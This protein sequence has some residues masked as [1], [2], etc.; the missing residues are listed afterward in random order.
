MD[1]PG[2]A[3]KVAIVTGAAGAIGTA[4]TDV[5]AARGARVVAVDRDQNSLQAAFRTSTRSAVM[6]QVADVTREE[7]MEALVANVVSRLGSVDI[8]IANAGVEG[9]VQLISDYPLAEFR[10]VLEVNVVGVFLGLKYV[11]PA[12]HARGAG[13]VVNIASIAGLMGSTH[14]AA[15]T[16]SK[17]AVIGLTRSAALECSG[18]AVRVNAVCPGFIDSPMLDAIAKGRRVRDAKTID[19][20]VPLKRLGTV[21]EVASL[22][23]FVASDEASYVT[24]S[25][26]TVD[27]GRTAA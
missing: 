2:F 21:H 23:A 11:L 6:S 8:F 20:R 18:T 24:G 22:V 1:V 14:L 25:V 17:H 26:F 7:D 5:L 27:G 12:M 16:A 9:P 3:G 4:I 10:R 19:A 15:Y 13:A